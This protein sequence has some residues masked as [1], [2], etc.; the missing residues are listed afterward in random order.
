MGAVSPASIQ[1]MIMKNIRRTIALLVLSGQLALILMKVQ[2]FLKQWLPVIRMAQKVRPD[3][4]RALKELR[5]INNH[6]KT[7]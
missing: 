4:I 3:A 5:Q 6:I 7:T 1:L 2:R